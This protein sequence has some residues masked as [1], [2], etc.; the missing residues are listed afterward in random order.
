MSLDKRYN[1]DVLIL[2]LKSQLRPRDMNN[3]LRM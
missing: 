2:Y 1:S 3:E